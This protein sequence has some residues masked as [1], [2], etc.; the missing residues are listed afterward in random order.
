MLRRTEAEERGKRREGEN[1]TT[2][3]S[4]P[5]HHLLTRRARA[6]KSGSD[7]RS[8]KPCYL[9]RGFDVLM[10]YVPTHAA[11]KTLSHIK[12]D[13]IIGAVLILACSGSAE[14]IFQTDDGSR[15]LPLRR[16]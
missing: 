14:H 8:L 1:N 3:R 2:E 5:Q 9:R 12:R 4:F 15:G 10:L 13:V 6:T 16:L 7:R 11:F